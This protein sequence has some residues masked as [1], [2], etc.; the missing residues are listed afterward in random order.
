MGCSAA[1]SKRNKGLRDLNDAAVLRIKCD[2][3][4]RDV[5]GCHVE[6]GLMA[7]HT[8]AKENWSVCMNPVSIAKLESGV[9]QRN[10]PGIMDLQ[11]AA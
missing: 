3:P 5:F 4:G 9:S 8:V 1:F 2:T 7:S 10:A 6:E 11:A